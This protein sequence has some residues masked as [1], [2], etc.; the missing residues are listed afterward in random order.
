MSSLAPGNKA[1]ILSG[2]NISILAGKIS[3]KG[4]NG[5][6]LITSTVIFLTNNL[7]SQEEVEG[8]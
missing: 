2:S 1:Y 3:A 4:H 5:S 7:F 6:A 8:C